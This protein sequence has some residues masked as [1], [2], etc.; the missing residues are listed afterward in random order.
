M[1]DFEGL[2]TISQ[3][4]SLFIIQ[5]NKDII[6]I[7]LPLPYKNSGYGEIIFI[8]HPFSPQTPPVSFSRSNL[9]QNLNMFILVVYGGMK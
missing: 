7:S 8:S 9:E 2:W 4:T 3:I 1:K 6:I 5:S